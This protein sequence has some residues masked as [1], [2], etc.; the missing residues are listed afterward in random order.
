MINDDDDDDDDDVMRWL[1]YEVVVTF[2][3]IKII[4]YGKYD[5]LFFTMYFLDEHLINHLLIKRER[6][7]EREL[8]I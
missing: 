2:K 3:K 7:R 1:W 5:V 6:E 4:L 8:L